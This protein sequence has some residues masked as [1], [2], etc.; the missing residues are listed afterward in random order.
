MNITQLTNLGQS[1][2]YDN[3]RR[4]MLESGEMQALFD[5]GIRG[6]TSNPT[7]FDKAIGQGD[8]YDDTIQALAG[9]GKSSNDIYEAL[10][11]EDIRRTADMLRPLFDETNGADGYVSLE[12]SPHLARDT[13]GTISEAQRFFDTLDRPNVMIKIPATPAGIP[14]ITETIAAG[15]NVNVTLM[16]SLKHYDAVAEAYISGLEKLSASGGDVAKVASVASFFVSRVDS[17]VNDALDKVGSDEA[18]ALRGHIAIDNAK[19][20]YQR[21]KEVFSGA[22][23]DKLAAQGAKVQR[24]LWAS[25]GTKDPAYA[26]TLYVDSLIGAHTVNTVPPQ[27]LTSFQDHGTVAAT[28][29]TDLDGVKERMAKLEQLNVDFDAIAEQLQDDGVDKFAASFDSLM[30][31]LEDKRQALVK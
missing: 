31:S 7:I 2:W 21:F 5:T 3:M 13:Q 18:F 8:D 23:W 9:E 22:R 27:T 19:A 29:E 6:V 28:L 15:I 16:F 20:A 25:T 11:I 30:Q 1:L 17:S 4:S 10:V 12:V 24:P 26:D 14:A